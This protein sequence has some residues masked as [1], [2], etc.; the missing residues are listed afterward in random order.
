MKNKIKF[1]LVIVGA[2]WGDEG[3]GKVVDVLAAKADIIVR[4][5]GGNNAGHTVVVNG[6]KFTLSLIPSGVLQKKELYIS[7]GVV[8]DPE[9]LLREIDFFTKKGFAPKL[10]LDPRVH[11]VM[12][13]HKALDAATEAWKGKKATG[14]LK[15]G[16]GYCYEDKN[17]RFGIRVEDL[18]EPA[19]LKEK[20]DM[21]L[22]L[23]ILQITK[24]FGQKNTLKKEEI[25]KT[26]VAYGKKLKKYVGDVS[27]LTQ[28]ALDKKKKVMFEG[29]HGTL[30]DSVFGTY[31]YTV[32]INTMS[33]AIFPYVGIAP[34]AV[35]S[36]G[37][38]KA[39][40]TRV[41]NG[42][43]P[44]E[45]F[46]TTG[47][48]IR[49]EGA[50]FGSVS[51]RPRRCGWLDIP[52]LRTATRLS[53]FTSLAITKMDV[54]SILPE[55]KICTHY[56]LG[57]NILKE[58]PAGMS[59]FAKCKPV[60]KI[61][62]GWKKPLTEIRDFAALPKEAKTYIKVIAQELGVPVRILSISPDR[63]GTILL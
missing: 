49:A 18:I 35:D 14:S 62:P 32:A 45:L 27:L 22:P 42:P 9:V 59:D 30:L 21:Y 53:G 51:K 36:V 10:T 3:K 12:P 23:K 1:P 57:N 28:E 52:M 50:E 5:N 40:T 34:Q 26:Y 48:K 56:K 8:I 29:A 6:E 43:F 46:N 39:Y 38:V 13:Y 17:N 24:V 19:R 61:L 47:E 55:I 60:Y 16:I 44:T 41:G 37:I 54:L 33:G 4:F 25:Y 58:I 2:Q 11:I 15:L 7:Q 63:K 31:P 20:L